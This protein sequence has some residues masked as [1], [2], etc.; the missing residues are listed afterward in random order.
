MKHK[1]ICI[2]D[3]TNLYRMFLIRNNRFEVRGKEVWL[4]AGMPLF[5]YPPSKVGG[6]WDEV[7]FPY[8]IARG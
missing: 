6:G 2:T 4:V 8:I 7:L 1:R 3:V 5:N